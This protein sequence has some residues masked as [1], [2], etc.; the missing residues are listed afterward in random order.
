MQGEAQGHDLVKVKAG[1]AERVLHAAAAAP[2]ARRR[3]F[4]QRGEAGRVEAEGERDGRAGAGGQAQGGWVHPVP[5]AGGG[6]AQGGVNGGGQRVGQAQAGG[7][8]LGGEGER[9]KGEG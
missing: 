3:R 4:G 6:G 9:E 5:V 7:V 2:G 8:G 1:Q